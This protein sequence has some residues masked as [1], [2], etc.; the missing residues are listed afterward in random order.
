MRE[1]KDIQKNKETMEKGENKQYAVAITGEL[2]ESI[3]I[4][5]DL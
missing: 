2:I 3:G 4:P 5:D 1:P